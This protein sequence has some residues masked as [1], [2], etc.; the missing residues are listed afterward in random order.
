M[1]LR[2]RSINANEELVVIKCDFDDE[3]VE[4]SRN[5]GS[6]K[7]TI[8]SLFSTNFMLEGTDHLKVIMCDSEHFVNNSITLSL[9]RLNYEYKH[10]LKS[11]KTVLDYPALV[12]TAQWTDGQEYEN[13]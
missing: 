4:M 2:I 3:V 7:Y 1:G 9:S 12:H 10:W 11:K 6:G 5:N 8:Q 13:D